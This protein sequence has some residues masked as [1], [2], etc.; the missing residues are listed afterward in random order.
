M[1]LHLEMLATKL[2][3]ESAQALP[4]VF[5]V[6]LPALEKR[7]R[8]ATRNSPSKASTAG[9]PFRSGR[10]LAIPLVERVLELPDLLQEVQM[11]ELQVLEALLQLRLRGHSIRR[12]CGIR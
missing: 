7:V 3:E 6:G 2:E 10:L 9:H 11:L 4:V 1:L 5:A 8:R 12:S